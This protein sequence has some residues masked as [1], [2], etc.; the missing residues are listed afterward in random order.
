MRTIVRVRA[1]A[2]LFALPVERVAEV[3]SAGGLRMLPDSKEGV[4]GVMR[5]DEDT[6]TVL[7]VLGHEGD[8]VV[9]LDSNGITF[10]LL[11]G[12]V[13]GVYPVADESIGPAPAGQGRV[14]VDGVITD[15]DEVA[16]LLDVDAMAGWLAS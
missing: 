12:E 13:T 15:Q 4:A 16:L 3:R 6:I 2:G 11:V 1:E 7:S 10:G 5:R 14:M 9:V 8:H